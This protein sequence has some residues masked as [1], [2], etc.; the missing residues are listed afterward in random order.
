LNYYKATE[1]FL[2]NY[3]SLKA[4]IEN[5]KQEIEE[6]EYLG[7]S[8]INY[9]H[10]I[11]G[12]TFVFHSITENEAIKVSE[13]KR[14]LETRIKILENKLERIDRAVDALNDIEQKIIKLR[15]YEEWQWCQIAYEV[16]YSEKWCRELRRRAVR[17]VAIGLFG[18][19]ALAKDFLYSSPY[20]QENAV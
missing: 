20:K 6:I 1:K 7:M 13:K 9:D 5:M 2:Y 18:E 4:S 10:E 19:E 12:K 14:I 15:Y 3:N 8:A 16:R 17:K 11:T